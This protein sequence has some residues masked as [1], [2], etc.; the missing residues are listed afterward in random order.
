MHGDMYVSYSCLSH[1]LAVPT[2]DT[3]GLAAGGAWTVLFA[4]GCDA[5][6]NVARDAGAKALCSVLVV[7]LH[8]APC[9]PN[10]PKP[11]PF[12]RTETE[13]RR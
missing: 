1:S 7:R 3:Y 13:Q 4:D 12:E 11:P 2:S 6:E 9:A 8:H 10:P 5:R